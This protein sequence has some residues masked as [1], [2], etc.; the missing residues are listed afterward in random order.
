MFS[1]SL[2]TSSFITSCQMSND[3]YSIRQY[4]SAPKWAW[5]LDGICKWFCSI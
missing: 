4:V 3:Y 1:T 5:H 2:L